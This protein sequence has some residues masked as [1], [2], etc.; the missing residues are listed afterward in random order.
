MISLADRLRTLQHQ[1]GRPAVVRPDESN[2]IAGT[3]RRMLGTRR[4]TTTRRAPLAA[5]VGREIGK[6]LQLVEH[7]FAWNGPTHFHMPWGDPSP[8]ECERLVCFDTETTGLAGGV[9]TKAFM[10]GASHWESGQLRVR[11]LY[12]TALVGEREMLRLFRSW[13]APDTVLIS[14]N[15]RSYDAPLLKGRFRLHGPTHPFDDLRHVDLLHPVRR[16]HRGHWANCRL[17]TVER[18]LLG[19]VR[20]DDLPG[21]EAPAAWLSF[22]RGESSTNLARVAEHNRQDVMTLAT[23]LHTLSD[24]LEGE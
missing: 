13:L 4:G 8:I 11:Q 2:D 6:G 24:R 18:E 12:L 7:A 5:P 23:L 21:S 17:Q 16:A 19:I 3:L 15:G 20:E 1:V 22:L 10:I 9:G 14:Y